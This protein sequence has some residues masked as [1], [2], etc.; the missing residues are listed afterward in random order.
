M[1]SSIQTASSNLQDIFRFAQKGQGQSGKAPPPETAA[2]K[3]L[4]GASPQSEP[5]SAASSNLM[6]GNFASAEREESKY[7]QAT[8]QGLQV[9]R[10]MQ[11]SKQNSLMSIVQQ[12]KMEYGNAESIGDRYVALKRAE[13]KIFWHQQDEVR[14]SA[15]ETHLKESKETLEDKVE[16]AMAPKDK[17][18]NPIDKGTTGSTGGATP[19][20]EISGS[21]PA[22]DLEAAP[23]PEIA[24]EVTVGEPAISTPEIT[25]AAPAPTIQSIDLSV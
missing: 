4:E 8:R 21:D 9:N 13:R 5:V 2:S 22:P 7:I 20:P 17:N 10:Q 19:M 3:L 14:K 1:I 6:S 25:V 12:A 11:D 18:G 23:A 15:E 16:E 24:P